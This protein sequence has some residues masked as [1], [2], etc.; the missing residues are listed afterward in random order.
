[1][2]QLALVVAGVL[3]GI[4]LGMQITTMS[5]LEE[6]IWLSGLTGAVVMLAFNQFV[7]GGS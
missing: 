4:A 3:V 1:M 5:T 7:R 2:K 6:W